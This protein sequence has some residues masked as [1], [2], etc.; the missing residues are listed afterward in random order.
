MV[1][2]AKGTATGGGIALGAT[3]AGA[4]LSV[5]GIALGLEADPDSYAKI[6]GN[7]MNSASAVIDKIVDTTFDV[8]RY[9]ASNTGTAIETMFDSDMTFKDFEGISYAEAAN[10]DGLEET[11]AAT[12]EF[13]LKNLAGIDEGKIRIVT[14]ILN[15]NTL[16][17]DAVAKEE[18]QALLD[19]A[20][21]ALSNLREE[22]PDLREAV[23]VARDGLPQATQDALGDGKVAASTIDDWNTAVETAQTTLDGID[24]VVDPD[25]FRAQQEVLDKAREQY[26]AGIEFNGAFDALKSQQ[27]DIESA[28]KEVATQ[29]ANFAVF[30]DPSGP[31]IQ[32]LIDSAGLS[33]KEAHYAAAINE[34]VTAKALAVAGVG[35]GVGA[36][37]SIMSGGTVDRWVKRIGNTDVGVPGGGRYG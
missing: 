13:L 26:E 6:A 17:F 31:K 35:A 10:W 22:L 27:T 14:E 11:A 25:G 30:E 23:S 12:Q 5:G 24:Q 1:S 20:T 2:I 21:E 7:V 9:G 32:K 34:H 19:N 37:G 33:E 3:V 28:I 16:T 36:T 4:G 15:D 29:R 18:A 8:V